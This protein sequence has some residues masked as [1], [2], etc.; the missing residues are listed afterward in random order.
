MDLWFS[1]VHLSSVVLVM[2]VQRSTSL[3]Y[4]LIGSSSISGV[5]HSKSLSIWMHQ[6][7][8]YFMIALMSLFDDSCSVF[9]CASLFQANFYS[10]VLVYLCFQ[11]LGNPRCL[12]PVNSLHHCK[13]SKPNKMNGLNVILISSS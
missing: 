5:V 1:L 6:R 4:L 10:P 9:P 12:L 2:M 8:I 7:F 11:T 13:D 3:Y